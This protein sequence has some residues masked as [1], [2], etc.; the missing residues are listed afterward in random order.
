MRTNVVSEPFRRQPDPRVLAWLRAHPDVMISSV[1]V[2]EL[3]VGARGLPHG[4]RREA[5][6]ARLGAV[7]DAH[8]GRIV[9]YDA[10]AAG[11]FAECRERRRAL[12]RPL[13]TED[14]MIAACARVAG[15]PL[16]TRNVDDFTDLGLDLVNPWTD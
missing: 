12:G 14:G 9:A 5:L 15:V 11:V 8:R 2:G 6:L 1:T 3:Y 10:P 7:L 16:A 4:R 13:A